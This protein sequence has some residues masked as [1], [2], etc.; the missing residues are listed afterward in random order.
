MV[1]VDI[2]LPNDFMSKISK[3][4]GNTDEIYARVLEAGGEIVLSKVR[5]N[6]SASIGKNLK[7]KSRS[8]GELLSSLGLSTA[9]VDRKGNHNI[10]VGFSE[11]RSDQKSNAMLA[12]VLEY[13]KSGQQAKPFMKPAKSQSRKAAIDAMKRKFEE[14]VNKL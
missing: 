10:K 12:S 5:S 9:K 2:K 1:K 4:R 8:S 3:L 14:E 13:G 6:L 7:G 11:P